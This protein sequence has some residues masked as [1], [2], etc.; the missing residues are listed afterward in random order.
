MNA[1]SSSPV[2]LEVADGVATITLDRPGAMNAVTTALAVGL[3]RALL[4]AGDDPP[5]PRGRP[6]WR[7]RQ[8]LRRRRLRRGPA[9]AR[10]RPGRAAPPVHRVPCS[11]RCRSTPSRSP[12]SRLSKG[13]RW[14]AGSSSC[15]PA[16]S[17]SSGTTPG[18]RT[19]TRTS[20]WCPAAVA[21][22]AC[23]GSSV[24]SGPWVCCSR[25][26][27]SPASRRWSGVSP[28]SPSHQTRST[29]RSTAF[30]ARLASRRTDSLASIKRLVRDGLATDLEAG[31]DLEL[32]TVVAHIAGQAGSTSVSAFA[33]RKE[34]NS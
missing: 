20:A 2:R 34:G 1:G 15:R 30:A 33:G 27:G 3:E 28:T 16:T 24:A 31:L 13:S 12:W 8:L 11:V 18:S 21:P 19:T 23:R 32:D 4:A 25:V 26:T 14:Q 10:R 6:S 17:C 22:S 7:G 5:R 9:A 29:R